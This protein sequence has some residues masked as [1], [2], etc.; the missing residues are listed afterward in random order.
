MQAESRPLIYAV[1]EHVICP[2]QLLRDM[3]HLVLECLFTHLKPGSLIAL[4]KASKVTRKLILDHVPQ[5]T[6]NVEEGRITDVLQVASRSLDIHL[7]LDARGAEDEEKMERLFIAA[8]NSKTTAVKK[9]TIYVGASHGTVHHVRMHGPCVLPC[10]A[11]HHADS[12][13]QLWTVQI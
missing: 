9:L 1:N 5:L 2:S 6:F 13:A 3:P 8:V 10:R 12:A 7:T 11:G 4:L